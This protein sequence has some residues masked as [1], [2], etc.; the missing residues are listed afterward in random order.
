MRTAQI[1]RTRAQR[2]IRP[3]R[4]HATTKRCA[5]PN[6]IITRVFL[7]LPWF[8][9]QPHYQIANLDWALHTV[10]ERLLS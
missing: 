3:A 8:I 5:L 7:I 1:Y 10:L 4:M 9:F 2:D 6:C